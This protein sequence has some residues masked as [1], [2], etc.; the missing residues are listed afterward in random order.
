MVRHEIVITALIGA[1]LGLPLGIFCRHF[2]LWLPELVGQRSAPAP[3]A[4]NHRPRPAGASAC[5][6]A[7]SQPPQPAVELGQSA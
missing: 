3:S 4:S 2:V 7:F 5:G 6:L 1:V